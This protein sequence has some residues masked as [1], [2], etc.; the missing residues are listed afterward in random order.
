MFVA[1]HRADVASLVLVD[2]VAGQGL[3]Q[4]QP[5]HAGFDS[6]LMISDGLAA[7]NHLGLLRLIDNERGAALFPDSMPFHHPPPEAREAYLPIAKRTSFWIDA[8]R[9]QRAIHDSVAAASDGLGPLGD[10]PP[11]VLSADDPAA[12]QHFLA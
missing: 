4:L 7:A 3:E 6:M 8:G 10:L 11:V 1:R 2:A 5:G 9:E 12:P